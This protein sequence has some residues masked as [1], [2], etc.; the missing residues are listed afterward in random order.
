MEAILLLGKNLLSPP[1]I[2]FGTGMAAV[3]SRSD[4]KFPEQVYQALTI[5]LLLAIGFKGGGALAQS[6]VGELALPLLGT[7]VA[8]SLIPV[9]VYFVTRRLL[10]MG[11][12]DAAAMGAHYGSVSAVTF[13]ACLAF[14]D[15]QGMSYEAYMPAV[16]ASLEIPSIFVALML[17]R[18][19]S[20]DGRVSV[21]ESIREVLSGKSLLL[22]IC[23]LLAGAGAGVEGRELMHPFLVAP[24]FGVLMLFLLEMGLVAG[25]KLKDARK[26]GWPLV[27]FAI[28]APLVQGSFG[29]LLGWM[30][31]L[32]QGGAV[33]FGILTASASYIAAPAAVRVALPDANPGYYVTASLGITFPFNLVVGIPFIYQLSHYLY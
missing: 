20:T 3:W 19:F 1:V 31:Q 25:E 11:N 24:F 28:V 15:R 30:M 13:M 29:L 12:S 22:L 33:V 6:S 8:G 21:G 32:S 26:M 17:A 7:L 18:R 5:Y 27:A 9:V 10:G 23:G 16:M 4:L 2:A 14:L